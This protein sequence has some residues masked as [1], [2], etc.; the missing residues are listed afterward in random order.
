MYPFGDNVSWLEDVVGFSTGLAVRMI[1]GERAYGELSDARSI[2]PFLSK[3][4]H[5]SCPSERS[6]DA[7]NAAHHCITYTVFF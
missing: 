5:N 6:T 7:R 3:V 2:P 1:E 4:I